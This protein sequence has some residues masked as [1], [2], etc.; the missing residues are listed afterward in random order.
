MIETLDVSL[1][2]FDYEALVS[3]ADE[4]GISA[5]D[6][7][8]FFICREVVHTSAFSFLLRG[9]THPTSND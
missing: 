1:A 3:L 6:L 8:L 2:S 5:E 7:A 4:I 9:G